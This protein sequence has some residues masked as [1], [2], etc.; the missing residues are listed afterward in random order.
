VLTRPI[1]FGGQTQMN[2]VL[3]VKCCLELEEENRF[4]K[5]LLSQ[6]H[7]E[8]TYATDFRQVSLTEPF[9]PKT[10]GVSFPS[11]AFPRF[12][13]SWAAR[14]RGKESKG[15]HSGGP[16]GISPAPI[17]LLP[18]KRQHAPEVKTVLLDAT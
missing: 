8:F 2:S 5:M 1:S 11:K 3:P 12:P 6:I 14:W 13:R 18:E 4:S 17:L 15:F 16:A 7:E 9:T 10:N